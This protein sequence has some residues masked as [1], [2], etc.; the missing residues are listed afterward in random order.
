MVN[1]HTFLRT[2][3]GSSTPTAE[4]CWNGTALIRST[5]FQG[6]GGE[7]TS[8][9]FEGGSKW[10]VDLMLFWGSKVV[11]SASKG[12][13]FNTQLL[14]FEQRFEVEAFVRKIE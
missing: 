12:F 9:F 11:R 7:Q 3:E 10:Y 13:V 8:K 5:N 6:R 14:G 1:Q 4:N 2:F